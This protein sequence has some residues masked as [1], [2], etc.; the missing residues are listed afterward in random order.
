MAQ[1]G[2]GGTQKILLFLF[3]AA[4]YVRKLFPEGYAFNR[5]EI[6]I[7]LSPFPSHVCTHKGEYFIS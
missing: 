3:I 5:V 1:R 7:I 6:Y 4:E 2:K